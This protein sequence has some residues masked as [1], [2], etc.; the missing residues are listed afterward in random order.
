M[1]ALQ[2]SRLDSWKAIAEY[3]GRNVR[4]AAR[5]AEQ[6]GMPV[7]RVPGG[8]RGAVFALTGEIDNW[9]L[10]Q[11]GD[12]QQAKD[13]VRAVDERS[14]GAHLGA[15]ETS[16]VEAGNRVQGSRKWMA[17]MW[18]RSTLR[19]G[20]PLLIIL[21]MVGGLLVVRRP[22]SSHAA[23]FFSI[24][25]GTDTLQAV[26]AGGNTLWVHKYPWPISKEYFEALKGKPPLVRIADFMG[27][28][29]NEA[30]VVVPF[31][32]GPDPMEGFQSELDFFTSAGKLAWTYLPR[33]AFRFGDHDLRD[34]WYIYDMFVSSGTKGASL[35]ATACHHTWGNSFVVQL[36]PRTGQPTLRFVNTGILRAL[37]EVHTSGGTYLL[38]G[39]FNNEWDGGSLAIINENRLFAASPQTPGT[40]H[41]CESCPRGDPDYYYVFPRSELNRISKLYE[42]PINV[43]RVSED[44][45]ELSSSERHSVGPE[46]IVYLLSKEPPFTLLSVRYNSDYDRLH[47][48]WSSEGKIHHSLAD[49]PER[50]HPKPIRVWTPSR[51][52]AEVQVKSESADQ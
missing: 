26:N 39:G 52:W 11:E 7:H 22:A 12:T 17:R 31:R 8:K 37:S 33:R 19:I 4:T 3:L 9:L 14:V 5:W 20:F 1:K 15:E 35:W 47:S 44:G 28:G 18:G 24:S 45:I 2:S 25:Y 10:K 46:N 30:A 43:V 36:D 23:Q 40:R 48:I 41:K 21:L 42:D 29:G 38:A 16:A 34:P 6:R 51:V 13:D 32:D 50:L 49:C 27:D